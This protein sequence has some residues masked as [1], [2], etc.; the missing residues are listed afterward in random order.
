MTENIQESLGS[1]KL[2]SLK[3][4]TS[5]NCW[6]SKCADLEERILRIML[7]GWISVSFLL[8]LSDAE[9]PAIA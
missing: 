1:Q 9:I 5:L 2:D 3:C 6:Q 8:M 4:L 7:D